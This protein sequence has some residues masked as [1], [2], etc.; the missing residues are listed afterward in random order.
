[1]LPRLSAIQED[2]ILLNLGNYSTFQ[3]NF[4]SENTSI[5]IH[6]ESEHDIP[7]ILYLG[8]GYHPNET[9]YDMKNHLF[10]KKTSGGKINILHKLAE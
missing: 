5:V 9:N 2:K 10:Y 3:V 8:H 7:L 4:T 6:L 1:M